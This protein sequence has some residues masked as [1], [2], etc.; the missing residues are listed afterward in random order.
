MYNTCMV[1]REVDSFLGSTLT[2]HAALFQWGDYLLLAKMC[3]VPGTVLFIIYAVYKRVNEET[4]QEE[5]LKK[6][7]KKEKKKKK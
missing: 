2:F 6:E 7:R 5:T 1:W 3:A 4:Q